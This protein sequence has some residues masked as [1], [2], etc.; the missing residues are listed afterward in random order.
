MFNFTANSTV[1]TSGLSGEATRS[2]INDLDA[3]MES[4]ADTESEDN[5][6]DESDSEYDDEND[7]EDQTMTNV[8]C[9]I[10]NF[11]RMDETRV[12]TSLSRM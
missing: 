3:R 11:K 10:Y 1:A 4:I 7:G 8:V 9:R 12:R 6:D 5:Q 2:G